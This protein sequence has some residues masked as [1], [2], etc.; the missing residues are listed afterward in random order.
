MQNFSVT[1]YTKNGDLVAFTSVAADTSDAAAADVMERLAG[2]GYSAD[3]LETPI[4]KEM[5]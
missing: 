5:Q 4:V 3:E 1:V 2:H